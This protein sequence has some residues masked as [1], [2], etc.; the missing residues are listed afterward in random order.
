M[1]RDAPHRYV[2]SVAA[3]ALGIV[4]ETTYPV[5]AAIARPK[6]CPI[7]EGAVLRVRKPRPYREPLQLPIYWLGRPA[8]FA[9]RYTDPAR[10]N[11]GF[12]KRPSTS[13]ISA[14]GKPLRALL[15]PLSATTLARHHIASVA[16]P[17]GVL[18]APIVRRNPFAEEIVAGR[19]SARHVNAADWFTNMHREEA[20]RS[21]GMR[22]SSGGGEKVDCSVRDPLALW[23]SEAAA[24]RAIRLRHRFRTLGPLAHIIWR[25]LQGAEMAELAPAWPF[26]QRNRAEAGRIRLRAGLE[27]CALMAERETDRLPQ[28]EVLQVTQ[29]AC[30]E[31]QKLEATRRMRVLI[32]ANDNTP[33]RIAA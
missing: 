8:R 7:P 21:E 4:G 6:G 32:P 12:P 2:N 11:R 19:I 13:V 24:D 9:K 31:C 20:V 18:R 27:L 10:E 25:A 23:P 30:A 22:S 29:A 3:E 15:R 26:P 17:E 33:R 5:A 16:V 14:A 28:W 1:V